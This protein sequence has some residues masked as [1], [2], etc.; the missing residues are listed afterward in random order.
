MGQGHVDL[1][2][3]EITILDEADHMADL[4]FLPGVRRIMDH[5]AP[6]RPAPALLGHARQGDR[7]PGQAL[8]AEP[9][10]PPGR[11]GAVAGRR[12]WTTTSCTWPASTASRSSPT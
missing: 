12:R 11:L 1:S 2:Q 3:V 5:D 8:P 6:Q 4:G 10:D 9:G 7:R